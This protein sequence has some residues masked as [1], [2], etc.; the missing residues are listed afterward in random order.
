MTRLTVKNQ[1]GKSCLQGQPGA[2]AQLGG[3]IICNYQVSDLDFSPLCVSVG[4]SVCLSPAPMLFFSSTLFISQGVESI[5]RRKKIIHLV[6]GQFKAAQG[7]DTD[8]SIENNTI[9]LQFI[10]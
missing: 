5:T 2:G 6:K 10:V 4:L 8:V 1:R 9:K 3:R 7:P